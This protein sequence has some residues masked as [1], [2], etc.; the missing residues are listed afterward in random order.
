MKLVNYQTFIKKLIKS[1]LIV[2]KKTKIYANK[3][4]TFLTLH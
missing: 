3:H 1:E 4:D 2:S